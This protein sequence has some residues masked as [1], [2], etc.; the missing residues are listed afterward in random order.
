MAA[1]KIWLI[2]EGKIGIWEDNEVKDDPAATESYFEVVV[3]R[4]VLPLV[5]EAVSK[6]QTENRR[7][8]YWEK[9]P[10]LE[11]LPVKCEEAE[12]ST[13]SKLAHY[14]SLTLSLPER[15]ARALSALVGGGT[16]L[17]N[18]HVRPWRH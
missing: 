9:D 6:S 7:V 2:R 1:R 17:L 10:S 15:T 4:K 16:L 13:T 8:V 18:T 11:N 5:L 14:F 3:N 12:S